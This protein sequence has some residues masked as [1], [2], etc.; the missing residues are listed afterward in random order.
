MGMLLVAGQVMFWYQP[1][2]L[3]GIA[4]VIAAGVSFI[5]IKKSARAG[6]QR[7]DFV[8]GIVHLIIRYQLIRRIRILLMTP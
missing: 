8:I 4:A 1:N 6:A 2:K 7:A 5:E 3:A